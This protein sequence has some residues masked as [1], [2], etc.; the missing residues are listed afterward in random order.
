MTSFCK[1]AMLPGAY[2]S[3]GSTSQPREQVSH[4]AVLTL[5]SQCTVCW[6][7]ESCGVLQ[8]MLWSLPDMLLVFD[9]VHQ[10]P[11][12]LAGT[13]LQLC[14]LWG[15][16]YAI[17]LCNLADLQRGAVMRASRIWSTPLQL[18]ETLRRP[19]LLTL[20]VP[21]HWARTSL[22]RLSSS[23]S[24]FSKS[25]V[26]TVAERSRIGPNLERI[27]ASHSLP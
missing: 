24:G 17:V 1:H 10:I 11:T 15:D 13:R 9:M 23:R 26:V 22:M 4:A 27:V 2:P 21:D 14:D 12:N 6:L 18:A 25:S 8:G 3:H 19:G 20:A 7:L 5:C 16:I